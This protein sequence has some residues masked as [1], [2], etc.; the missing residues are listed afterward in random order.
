MSL[1]LELQEKS[2]NYQ[3]QDT[4]MAK[5]YS[6]SDEAI[7]ATVSAL[8]NGGVVIFPTETVYALAC[9]AT[10]REAVEKIYQIKSRSAQMPLSVLVSDIKM[11]SEYVDLGEC[12][13]MINSFSPGP[14]TYVL[15]IVN[16]RSLS[17]QIL[18]DNSVGFRIPAYKMALEILEKVGIPLVGTSVN[19][20]G[21]PSAVKFEEIP[22]DILAQVDYVIMDNDHSKGIASTVVK[23]HG[24]RV[25]LLRDGAI[26][27]SKIIEFFDKN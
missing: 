8:L 26:P 1:K 10:N 11:I 20:S 14:I 18:R 13:E 7:R 12:A 19:I 4:E 27:F 16:I 2:C 17:P 23:I 3:R 15:D 5:I 24:H 25:E 22:S 21:Q 9:D 6:Y